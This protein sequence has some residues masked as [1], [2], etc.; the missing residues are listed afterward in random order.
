MNFP[1]ENVCM[2]MFSERIGKLVSELRR[3]LELRRKPKRF[4]TFDVP[5]DAHIVPASRIQRYLEDEGIV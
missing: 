5:G 3:G 2:R 1:L 4:P